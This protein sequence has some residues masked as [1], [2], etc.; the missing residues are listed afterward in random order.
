MSD[1]QALLSG[2][3]VALSGTNLLYCVLGVVLGNLVGV[4][5]GLG[6]T[7]TIALLLPFAFTLPPE[8]G[9]IMM[10]GIYYGAMYGGS[11]TSILLDLPGEAATVVTTLDGYQMTRQGRA[12]VALGIAAIGS[13]AAGTF[14]LLGLQFLAPG[15]AEFAVRFG[16]PEYTVLTALGIVLVAY[17]GSKAFVKS[18]IC[19]AFGLILAVVGQDPMTG[20]VRF[21]FGSTDL[22]GGFDFAAIAMGVFGIGEILYSL[23]NLSKENALPGRIGRL[24]PSVKDF[25]QAKWAIVRG[26]V[27]GFFIGILPGGGAILATVA[28]YSLEK[29]LSRTPEKFGKGTIEGVAAPESANNAAA[30]AAFIPLLTLGIPTDAVM[31]LMFGALLLHGIT[32]GPGLIA[33][34][35]DVFWGVLSSM[36]IGNA[37]LLLLNLPFVGVFIQI[38][39][40]KR[41]VLMSFAV[42]VTMIGVYS[43]GND[44]FNMWAVLAFGA[45][46]YVMRK[47]G[48][49][50]SPL[51]LAFVLGQVL[52]RSFRQSM[53]MSNGDASVFV[54]RPFSGSMLAIVAAALI[55]YIIRVRLKKAN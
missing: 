15:L 55:F 24:W 31:A 48:F 22:L 17:L 45:L 18:A 32:P 4:L 44:E 49:E 54:Q 21:T 41:V 39:R 43:L 3:E 37:I 11:I 50:P 36:Y 8:T 26:S 27:T 1:F 5:P 19:A 25:A 16:A 13:F 7:A 10:A 51:V 29:R 40:V 33:D 52:E 42:L 28:A 46:G 35:P 47:T 30:G 38:L 53:I 14:A 12:G 9:L 6:P 2:F 23:E 20:T 34:H